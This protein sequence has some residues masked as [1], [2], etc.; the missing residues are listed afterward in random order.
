MNENIK[1]FADLIWKVADTLRSIYKPAEYGK[2]ILPFILLRRLDCVLAPNQDKVHQEF[3]KIKNYSKSYESLL[4][5][6]AGEK[7]SF[8][9]HSQYS[10][11]KIKDDANLLVANIREYINGFSED[12]KD[13]FLYKFDFSKSQ[14]D[15]LEDA[16]ILLLVFEHFKDI[17][18]HPDRV[19]NIE[20]GYIFEE[21]IR[22]FSE[23]SNETSGEHFTPR[24]VV[25]LLVELLFVQDRA[26]FKEN[27]IKTIYDGACGTGGMLSYSE[28]TLH[29]INPKIVVKLFGQ[30]VNAES[31][32]ICKGDML[33]KG[34]DANNIR[35]GN[36]FTDDK[37]ETEKF[38]YML[39]NPPFGVEWKKEKTFIEDEYSKK[40]Y[41][42]RFGAGLPRINDGA[43]LF[44]QHLVSK[45]KQNAEGTRIGIIFNG[46]PL[47]TGSAGSGESNIRQWIIERDMLE[48]IVALPNQLFYNTG[49][50]TYIWILSNRKPLYRKGKIQLVNAVSFYQKMK[51]SLGDK[52]NEISL[53]QIE[54]I[55]KLYDDFKPNEYCKIFDN[56][57][58]GYSQ[59]AVE[60]PAVDENG[61]VIKDKKDKIKIAY[62]DT[63]NVPLKEDIEKYFER[64]VKPHLPEAQLNEKKTKVG[65][66][67]N[68]TKHF[69]EYKP[70]RSVAEICKEILTLEEHTDGM[71]KELMTTKQ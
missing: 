35:Y 23:A 57:D 55:K 1:S 12:L 14:L 67:I 50:S 29:N 32:A 8:H 19:S 61:E 46:S 39:V 31:F 65:Y 43:L 9:N 36:S 18:L 54:Q 30:E 26:I 47:F 62:T 53:E 13:I 27:S 37:F 42:G 11:Q 7:I 34:Q 40:G 5:Q 10:F 2:V 71:L 22:K 64:E 33:I 49:I 20:M 41:S 25:K 63:E 58:F 69:Y 28:E 56:E 48:C 21:L 60:V 45:M 17:D 38:D 15:K 59:I 70:L 24:E 44:L 6:I 66:E 3:L 68:F 16:N 4:N 52:R 51:R